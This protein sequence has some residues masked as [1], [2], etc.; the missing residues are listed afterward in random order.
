MQSSVVVFPST[1]DHQS[2]RFVFITSA[3]VSRRAQQ[4]KSR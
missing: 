1:G 4:R 2:L 3:R